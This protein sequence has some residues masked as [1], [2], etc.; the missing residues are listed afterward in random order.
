MT[1][2]PLLSIS[3]T[4]NDQSAADYI[5]S[6]TWLQAQ[7]EFS[8]GKRSSISLGILTS[9]T[10]LCYKSNSREEPLDGKAQSDQSRNPATNKWFIHSESVYYQSL[11]IISV[12]D[13]G[14]MWGKSLSS[15]SHVFPPFIF[16]KHHKQGYRLLWLQM[17]L[18]DVLKRPDMGSESEQESLKNWHLSQIGKDLLDSLRVTRQKSLRWRY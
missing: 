6:T 5:T 1:W 9:L 3:S 7:W 15:F 14:V 11:Y 2:F 17:N 18:W 16:Q 13:S 12:L 8:K 4:W 10:F